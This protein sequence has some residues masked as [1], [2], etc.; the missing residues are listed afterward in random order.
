MAFF[1]FCLY[2]MDEK[3]KI[4]K[5][6]KSRNYHEILVGILSFLQSSCGFRLNGFSEILVC[7]RRI[8]KLSISHLSRL[9]IK[10]SKV[11]DWKVSSLPSGYLIITSYMA[12]LLYCCIICFLVSFEG[13]SGFYIACGGLFL[14]PLHIQHELCLTLR[15]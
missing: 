9:R 8:V 11:N 10:T 14:K 6:N 2:T 12:H 4:C 15:C 5:C 7:R 1:D 3:H 13:F